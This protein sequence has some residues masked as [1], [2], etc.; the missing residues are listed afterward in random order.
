MYCRQHEGQ[1]LLE[2]VDS[3]KEDNHFNGKSDD[4]EGVGS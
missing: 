3:H 4:G 1:S 2:H